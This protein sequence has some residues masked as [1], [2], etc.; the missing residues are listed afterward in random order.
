MEPDYYR[1]FIFQ[2]LCASWLTKYANFYAKFKKIEIYFN[3]KVKYFAHIADISFSKF[4]FMKFWLNEKVTSW[5]KKRDKKFKDVPKF[6][7]YMTTLKNMTTV[8]V[9]IS[10]HP[11][12]QGHGTPLCMMF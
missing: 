8:P 7:L 11:N 1:N 10:T 4:I 9:Q 3:Q 6:F 12:G 5:N 2:E